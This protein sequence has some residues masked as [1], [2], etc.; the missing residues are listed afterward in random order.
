MK[1]YYAWTPIRIGNKI[2][3]RGRKVTPSDLEVDK[4]TFEQYVR[5]GAVRG[6]SFPA[7]EGYEGALTDYIREL[8]RTLFS[9]NEEQSALA[10]VMDSAPSES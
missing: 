2:I 3:P 9:P 10:E 4:E 8:Q 7:P 1:T 6:E 5:S